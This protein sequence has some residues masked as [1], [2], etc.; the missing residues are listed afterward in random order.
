[1]DIKV[2]KPFRDKDNPKK[3]FNV[4]DVLRDVDDNRA[5]G[6]V[7]RGLASLQPS[8]KEGENGGTDER[9]KGETKEQENGKTFTPSTVP[10]LTPPPPVSVTDIDLSGHHFKIIAAVKTFA[11]VDKLKAALVSEEASVK[12]RQ[13][14]VD[15]LKAR[16]SEIEA[17]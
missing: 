1:M 9:E 16:I 6:L 7:L 13:A 15:A 4:G 2:E 10:P 5:R 3:V 17:Q 8:P 14:I 11:D 12:P